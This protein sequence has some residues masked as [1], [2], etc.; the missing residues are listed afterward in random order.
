MKFLKTH[1]TAIICTIIGILLLL[2]Q[3]P[4]T[5]AMVKSQLKKQTNLKESYTIH[6]I[7]NLPKQLD[8]IS[9][10]SWLTNYTFACVQDEDGII[11]IYDT[12]QNKITNTYPFAHSGDYEGIAIVKNDAFVMRSDGLLYHI[13]NYKSENRTVT[14]IQT[15]FSSDN[16]IESLGFDLDNNRLLTAP[17]EK[18]LGNDNYKSIYEISLSNEKLETRPLVK[19]DLRND[20][21]KPFQHKNIHKTLNPSDIAIHP[22]TKDMY[23]LEGK[24]P[25]L[26]ILD[27]KGNLKKVYKLDEKQFPQPEGITF[28]HDGKLY[29]SNEAVYDAATIMEITFK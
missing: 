22:K 23:M 5:R 12:N 25:K 19:I 14:E 20:K 16:D 29:I 1:C 2:L 13:I 15:N 26:L 9:G 27:Q 6:T 17:K 28:S 21:L 10:L 24:R 8:E 11:F 7:W 18:D 4:A 3:G